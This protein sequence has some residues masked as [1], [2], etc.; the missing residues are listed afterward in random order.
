MAKAPTLSCC[1]LKLKW[2]YRNSLESRISYLAQFIKSAYILLVTPA[3]E[4]SIHSYSQ[5]III[6]IIDYYYYN[7]LLLLCSGFCRPTTLE[8]PYAFNVHESPV[9]CTQFYSE[10]P[11]DFIK[12]LSST[13]VSRTRKRQLQRE[14]STPQ[15]CWA[16][17][18]YSFLSADIKIYA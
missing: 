16:K 9:T 5:L 1:K 18:E 13:A 4:P 17:P 12:A 11:K 3:D 7:W 10:C 14:I 8:V 2:V 6:I 15:V